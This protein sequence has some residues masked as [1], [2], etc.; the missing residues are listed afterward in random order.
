MVVA[1]SSRATAGTPCRCS[2]RGTSSNTVADNYIGTNPT[3]NSAIANGASGVA[4][5]QGASYNNI[6]YNLISGNVADGVYISDAGTV[7]N[8]IQYD[9]I[10]NDNATVMHGR[11]YQLNGVIVIF[12]STWNTPFW[13]SPARILCI[14]LPQELPSGWPTR[15]RPSGWLASSIWR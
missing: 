5:A 2:A 3:G 1:T 12:G 14:R 7:Y 13:I 10:G 8:T 11:G 9:Y 4:I 15:S 6:A